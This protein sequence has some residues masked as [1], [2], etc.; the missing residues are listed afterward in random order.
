MESK[1]NMTRLVELERKFL[2]LE[3]QIPEG[4]EKQAIS[5]LHAM[6][7]ETSRR[8]VGGPASGEMTL[9]EI[10][11]LHKHAPPMEGRAE[12]DPLREGTAAPDFVLLDDRANRIRLADF[13]GRSV[14]LVFYPLDWSPTCSD[15][16][17]LYQSEMGEFERLDTEL[18]G[19]S[20]DSIYSHGAWAAVRGIKFRLLADF[21]PKG[22][23]A[24]RY[25]VWREQDGFSERALYVVDRGGIIRYGHVSPELHK[26]PDI[27]EL[28]E[29]LRG[30]TTIKQQAL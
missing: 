7:Q 21:H 3:P 18:V 10:A 26:V 24:R 12:N 15:Q 25:N 9:E 2:E 6:I 17:S 22:E 13:K 27:Y 11:N 20:V 30:M 19:I 5:L 14:V 8:R 23:V 1:S 16:L 28:F 4:S 29:V